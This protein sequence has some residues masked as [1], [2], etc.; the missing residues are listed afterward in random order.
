MVKVRDL[1]DS[2]LAKQIAKYEEILKKL[3]KERDRRNPEDKSDQTD[4]G[5]FQFSLDDSAI[6][7][8]IPDPAGADTPES[9]Q[10]Q[11]R[12]TQLLK[13][14]RAELD[15]LQNN[16]SSEKSRLKNRPKMK[17]REK[18]KVGA[19]PLKE[20]EDPAKGKFSLPGKKKKAGEE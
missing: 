1:T 16:K 15:E 14:S 6:M 12:V 18:T 11:I 17:V 8:S 19:R 9:E 10:E 7:P 13:L 2:Q 5:A 4:I 20:N 3:T